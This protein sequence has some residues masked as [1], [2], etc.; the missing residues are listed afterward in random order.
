[1]SISIQNYGSFKANL[2]IQWLNR[3]N[4]DFSAF[5]A[6]NNDDL[7]TP[8]GIEEIL[9]KYDS[10]GDYKITGS[11]STNLKN[12]LKNYKAKIDNGTLSEKSKYNIFNDDNISQEA[13]NEEMEAILSA[14]LESEMDDA[15]SEFLKS[16]DAEE[17]F[18]SINKNDDNIIDADEFMEYLNSEDNIFD[19]VFDLDEKTKEDA[20]KE[21]DPINNPKDKNYSSYKYDSFIQDASLE[22]KDSATLEKEKKAAIEAHDK[23]ISDWNKQLDE[24]VQK[25]V[26]ENSPLK[27]EY[28]NA[29]KEFDDNENKISEINNSLLNIDNQISS[30]DQK[31]AG[32]QVKISAADTMSANGQ[33]PDAQ[34]KASLENELKNA[35]KEK[36]DL[37]A[38]KIKE[39]QQKQD[40]EIKK[41]A[42]QKNIDDCLEKIT[43]QNSTYKSE[44]DNL[45]SKI[46]SEE[47]LKKQT[48]T[49]YNT[50]IQE[51][52]K[53]ENSSEF[54]NA[55][56]DVATSQEA[57]ET[58]NGKALSCSGFVGW[59]LEKIAPQLPKMEAK[60]CHGLIE[61]GKKNDAW[62]D[63]TGMNTQ[64]A[65]KY[66][67][68]NLRPG[69]V[70]VTS[71]VRSDGMTQLHVGF[72]TKVY[73][74]GSYDTIEA[75]TYNP[76]TQQNQSVYSHHI[77][78]DELSSTKIEGFTDIEKVA[79][80]YGNLN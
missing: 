54:A 47:A 15:G 17:L 50:Q 68:E 69:M 21:S 41:E 12:D 76:K 77:D 6:D 45:R 73:E 2:I 55:L 59:G 53:S 25:S 36:S 37:E 28:D 5:N 30:L 70:F 58:W 16:L 79:A 4:G 72:V 20:I 22:S 35:Q 7:E 52:K 27:N 80:I 78:L 57:F 49:K 31:I 10:N 24:L 11:E 56:I 51:A 63:I 67:S 43:S 8:S 65:K 38:R 60:S 29:K 66:L 74:D 26:D 32:L 61:L 48:E 33:G 75:N 23:N 13:F 64:D 18:K 19:T 3:T 62:L 44:I 40:L 46:K 39:E 71:H 34:V 42:L 14:L 9:L 1:M